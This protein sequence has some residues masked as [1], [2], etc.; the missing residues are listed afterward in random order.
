MTFVPAAGPQNSGVLLVGEAPGATEARLGRPFV[1]P[2]GKEQEQYLARCGVSVH[3]WRRTN[4]VPVYTPGNPDPTAAQIREWSP[5][6]SAEIEAC[7]PKVIVTVGAFATRWFLGSQATMELTHGI[8]HWVGTLTRGID[9]SV[10]L[11]NKVSG[12]PIVVPVL[13]PAGGLYSPDARASIAWDYAQAAR[14]VRSVAAGQD[15]E[16]AEDPHAGVEVYRDVSGNQL[17]SALANEGPHLQAI[18]IDTETNPDGSPWSI[19]VSVRPGTGYMLRADSPDVDLGIA[20]IQQLINTGTI[21]I[22]HNA[23]FDIGVCYRMGLDLYDPNIKIWDTMYGAYLLR[24]EPQGLK[25]L[26]WRWCGMRMN[27]YR[28]VVAGAAEDKQAAYL[29]EVLD[30]KWPK[31]EPI[32][33]MGND[34]QAKVRRPWTAKRRVERILVDYYNGGGPEGEVDLGARWKAIDD[35]VRG[36]VEEVLDPFPQ[37]SLDDTPLEDATHYACR[38][39]D[40]TLRLYRALDPV[41]KEADLDKL[42]ERGMEVLP[43]FS[44]MQETGMTASK[45]RFEELTAE[46]ETELSKLQ[47]YISHNYF[48]DR[49][50]NPAS[51]K[52]VATLLRRRGLKGAKR[53][54]TGQ[55]STSSLSISHLADEDEAV[56]KVMEWRGHQKTLTAFCKPAVD[57]F[58]SD[59]PDLQTV[60]CQIKPTR[61][62]TRRLAAAEPNLLQVPPNIRECYV[63]PPGEVFYAAD[64]AQI[65]IRVSAHISNDPLLCKF[66]REGTDIHTETACRIFGITPDE[67]DK[68]E[69]RT[70]AK[71]AS[72]GIIYG[73]QGEG[74][75]AQ[76][77]AMGCKGWTAERCDDLIRE[78]LKVYSGIAEEMKRTSEQVKRD[79]FVRDMWNMVRYL[80]GIYVPGKLQAEAERQAFNHR[81]QGGA[82]GMI[83]NSTS[84]LRPHIRDMQRRGLGVRWRLQ[85]HDELVFSVPEEHVEEL[86]VLV[87]EALTQHHGVED[88]RVP[89]EADSHW[90]RSWSDLK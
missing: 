35:V 3:Q 59:G 89:V 75:L 17:L 42:V 36:P 41:L 83:Q 31:I 67:M 11:T 44:E 64:L 25:P 24:L 10:E 78:W 15:V 34:G 63:A 46:L 39:A 12:E 52:Q 86:D 88:M 77:R 9:E 87:K 65:E 43:V 53:T 90:G 47:S 81:V 2:S 18:G 29:A 37:P 61:I 73:V 55:V 19:Q 48:D 49:P 20:A 8:P 14:V 26:A 7:E 45:S 85:V 16:I 27:S 22:L 13:H 5:F 62:H 79:G 40:A 82:Q 70:P 23:M 51:S 66:L 32:V 71:R 68:K 1:G 74:L 80:P 6:L 57:R 58:D 60:R 84:W 69:H 33:E 54:S 30:R 38:D 50:F 4:V 56:A 21:A 72:F 28:D 76:L